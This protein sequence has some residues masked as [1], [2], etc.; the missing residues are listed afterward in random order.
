GDVSGPAGSRGVLIRS[1]AMPRT[2]HADVPS[3]T[4]AQPTAMNRRTT[5]ARPAPARGVRAGSQPGD[6]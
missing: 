4:P 2:R 5:P 1:P 3:R 6:D